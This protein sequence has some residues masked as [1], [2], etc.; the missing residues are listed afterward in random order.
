M[1]RRL[2]LIYAQLWFL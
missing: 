1:S 2:G